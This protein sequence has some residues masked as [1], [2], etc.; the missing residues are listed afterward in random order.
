MAKIKVGELK[1]GMRF[2]E[3]A[4]IEDD[5][6]FIQAELPIKQKEIDRLRK[7]GITEISTEGHLIDD[8]ILVKGDS[9]VFN[10]IIESH[11]DKEV[12]NI[13]TSAVSSLAGVFKRIQEG[14][15]RID[16][17]EIDRIINK[18]LPA[19]RE[20]KEDMLS[21]IIL[22]GHGKSKL[23]VSSVNC[24][25][26]SVIIG[27]E[28]KL[29]HPKLFSLGVASLLHDIGMTRIPANIKDKIG[30]LEENE[31]K[32]MKTHTLYSYKIITERL[33]YPK[34]IGKIAMQHHERWDGKGYPSKLAGKD[35]HIYAR[36][37]S[38]AD[39]FEAMIS[40]R[41]YRNSMIGYQAMRQLL[42]D[43][44][45]RFDSNVLKVFIKTMGIYPIGS[46]VLLN[47]SSIGRVTIVH[48]DAPLRPNIKIIVDG[49]G[50]K[51]GQD[52]SFINLLKEKD[53]YITKAI[54]PDEI[55]SS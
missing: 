37:M 38:V 10:E 44:S 27:L 11:V 35:I 42:N 40:T 30:N 34:E 18:L 22:S 6:L 20:K 52:G 46:I 50:N 25:I 55:K 14:N 3:P 7:W 26:L 12:L 29:T 24:M 21:F 31:L 19:I 43:N 5:S 8:D 1:P 13:Y 23:A 15:E 41:P 4:Y 39:A 17:N 54:N 45:R 53:L 48:K 16:K 28:I 47:D 33:K 9:D 2:S 51:T 36:I 49:E 32:M